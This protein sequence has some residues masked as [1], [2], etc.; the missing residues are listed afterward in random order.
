MLDDVTFEPV[1]PEHPD[2]ARLIAAMTIEVTA[3][4]SPE[5]IARVREREGARLSPME[6]LLA[7]RG[8]RAIGMR[9][10]SADRRRDRGTQADVR[11][12]GRARLRRRG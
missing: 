12:A 6:L 10:H 5:E 2:A 8:G 7:R 3:L 1:S 4:Y 9:R 11:R